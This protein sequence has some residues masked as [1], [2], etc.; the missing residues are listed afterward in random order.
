MISE[1]TSIKGASFY[2][3][4]WCHA[5]PGNVLDL[6]PLSPLLGFCILL[7][8]LTNFYKTVESGM[9]LHLS[10]SHIIGFDDLIYLC[11]FTN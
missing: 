7:T 1:T 10:R 9:D 2:R 5:N 8:N 11:M 4:N 6:T 3:G